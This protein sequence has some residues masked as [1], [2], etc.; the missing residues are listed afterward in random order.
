MFTT[1]VRRARAAALV[2]TLVASVLGVTASPAAAGACYFTGQY[3]VYTSSTYANHQGQQATIY[4]V[5]G[6][7][8]T[9][10]CTIGMMNVTAVPIAGLNGIEVG[11]GTPLNCYF[12]GPFLKP[13][14]TTQLGPTCG[15]YLLPP[16]VIVNTVNIFMSAQVV[17]TAADGSRV[18]GTASCL[19]TFDHWNDP[20]GVSGPRCPISG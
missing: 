10:G 8:D 16:A 15:T 14:W 19:V 7:V 6:Y 4:G 20:G 3:G 9:S 11:V 5:G 12:Y 2:V 18:A 13:V 17:L 1:F